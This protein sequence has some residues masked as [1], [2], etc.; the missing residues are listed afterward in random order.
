MF[1][2]HSC[3]SSD[4]RTLDTSRPYEILASAFGPIESSKA[5]LTK[6]RSKTL[7]HN[8]PVMYIGDVV[9]TV[10]TAILQGVHP[11]LNRAGTSGSYFVKAQDGKTRAIFKPKVRIKSFECIGTVSLAMLTGLAERGTVWFAQPQVVK[12]V[13]QESAL[14]FLR[15]WPSLS[16]SQF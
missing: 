7:D 3:A 16:C 12:M 15:L 10:K 6:G 13:S 8:E 4:K 9:E 14:A 5:G 2:L 11:R 1:N